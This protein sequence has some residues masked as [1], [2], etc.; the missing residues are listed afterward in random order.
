[1]P[2][3]DDQLYAFAEWLRTTPLVDLS[4]WISNRP[5]SMTMGEKFLTIPLLQTIHILA[6]AT[7]FVSVL[8]MN[9]RVLGVSGA[10][11]TIAETRRRYVPWVWGALLTLVATGLALVV[12]EPVRELINPIFWVKMIMIV[13]LVLLSVGFQAGLRATTAGRD[14]QP[15][16]TFI[17]IAA[18]GLILL[19]CL[20]IVAGRWI[21]YAPA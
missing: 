13:A 14:L 18:A 2:W 7:A 11:M 21:A 9:L 19:W 4:L 6:I 10:G 5:L 17:R 15:A 12:A 1:M 16:G 8:M 20:V 3:M